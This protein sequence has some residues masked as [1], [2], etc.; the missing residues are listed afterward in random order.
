MIARKWV[1]VVC[2]NELKMK[3]IVQ[4]QISAIRRPFWGHSIRK[5]SKETL[6]LAYEANSAASLNCTFFRILAYCGMC[7]LLPTPSIV[8]NCGGVKINSCCMKLHFV[9]LYD[10]CMMHDLFLCNAPLPHNNFLV[11]K[12]GTN[13]ISDINIQMTESF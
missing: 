5:S 8:S 12:T 3:K 13:S 2:H 11:K 7:V 10:A 4:D 1:E 6:I 9:S